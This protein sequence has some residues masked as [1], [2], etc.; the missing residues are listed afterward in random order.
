MQNRLHTDGT[1]KTNNMFYFW[2]RRYFEFSY[3]LNVMDV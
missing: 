2:T 1:S 3:T